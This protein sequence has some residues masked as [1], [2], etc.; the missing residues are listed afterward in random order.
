LV[1]AQESLE[2][3]KIVDHAKV[4]LM[5][6]KGL[7]EIAALACRNSPR[8]SP[9][10]RRKLPKALVPDLFGARARGEPAAQLLLVR[11]RQRWLLALAAGRRTVLMTWMTP[12]YVSMSALT[13]ATRVVNEPALTAVATMSSCRR[14]VV[15]SFSK[16]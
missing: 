5:E 6:R 14:V 1:D 15:I 4:I 10:V 7:S 2:A 16:C 11:V 12:F 8:A 13:A 3:R 9:R